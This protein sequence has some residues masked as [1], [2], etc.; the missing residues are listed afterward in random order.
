MIP[1]ISFIPGITSTESLNS[2]TSLVTALNTVAAPSIPN[3]SSAANYI[4]RPFT[5]NT[6]T[7]FTIGNLPMIAPLIPQA[8]HQ[9]PHLRVINSS[10]SQ[11]PLIPQYSEATTKTVDNANKRWSKEE[12]A[13]VMLWAN[14]GVSLSE[15]GNR[16]SRS[17]R[18]IKMRVILLLATRFQNEGI[19]NG[20]QFTNG[21]VEEICRV[22]QVTSKEV[23]EYNTTTANTGKLLKFSNNNS[24]GLALGTLPTLPPLNLSVPEGST[25]VSNNML[26]EIR[27]LL[28]ALNNKLNNTSNLTI[29]NGTA[30]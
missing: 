20:Q 22:H 30:L 9:Q 2:N 17:T 21:S 12:E 8:S 13:Q 14:S 19:F 29:T 25:L 23:L 24:T 27:D 3:I 6:N 15:I 5:A 7:T 18:A 28:I 10:I 16:V 1:A 11:Q 26:I 4:S